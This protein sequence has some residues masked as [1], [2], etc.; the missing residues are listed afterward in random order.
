ML[1]ETYQIITSKKK[2]D[3]DKFFTSY[4][5]AANKVDSAYYPP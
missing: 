1:R 3:C 2:L 4:P 5:S